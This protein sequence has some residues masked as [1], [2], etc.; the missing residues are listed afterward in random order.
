[1]KPI[2]L[3]DMFVRRLESLKTDKIIRVLNPVSDCMKFVTLILYEFMSKGTQKWEHVL[4]EMKKKDLILERS[5]QKLITENILCFIVYICARDAAIM[6]KE[7]ERIFVAVNGIQ[8]KTIM[9]ET[10]ITETVGTFKTCVGEKTGI[11]VEDINLSFGGKYLDDRRTLKDYNIQNNSTLFALWKVKGGMKG[12][13]PASSESK[14]KKGQDK[15]GLEGTFIKSDNRPTENEPFSYSGFKENWVQ[16]DKVKKNINPSET[17]VIFTDGACKSNPGITGAG[18]VI[19]DAMGSEV[20]TN[21]LNLQRG[22]N[23]TAEYYGV[24]FGIRSALNLGIKNLKVYTDSELVANQ[25]K[26][27]WQVGEKLKSFHDEVVNLSKKFASMDVEWIPRGANEVADALAKDGLEAKDEHRV[28]AGVSNG[29]EKI[30]S[31]GKEISNGKGQ[32]KLGD[33]FPVGKK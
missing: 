16:F 8:E 22:T 17:Y 29:T 24:I 14:G 20:Y 5:E 6:F 30:A 3:L 27:T 26:G 12:K 15:Q 11:E 4:G 9:I 18:Y 33:F 28:D 1:M 10:R 13:N 32:S 7:T 31:L 21:S 23:N 2:T 19:Y 25:F